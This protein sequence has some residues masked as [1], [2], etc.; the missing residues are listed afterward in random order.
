MKHAWRLQ[1]VDN[2][3]HTISGSTIWDDTWRT[4]CRA[5]EFEDKN[6]H[7]PWFSV[8][9]GVGRV[10]QDAVDTA[11]WSAVREVTLAPETALAIQNEGT[12]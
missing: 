3:N 6:W 10:I 12:T 2:A 8:Q 5:A 11:P 9:K 4:T 7:E 1:D